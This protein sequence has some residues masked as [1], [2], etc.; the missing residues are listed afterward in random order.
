MI[1]PITILLLITV[2]GHSLAQFPD[3]WQTSRAAEVES[4]HSPRYPT[5]GIIYTQVQWPRISLV[6]VWRPNAMQSGDLIW[7]AQIATLGYALVLSAFVLEWLVRSLT[8]SI[9]FA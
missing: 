1:N 3:N 8:A 4:R 9:Q 5:M 7:G 2:T 6:K